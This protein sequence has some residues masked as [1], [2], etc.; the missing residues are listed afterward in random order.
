MEEFKVRSGS[1]PVFSTVYTQ[2]LPEEFTPTA[3]TW[4]PPSRSSDSG[5]GIVGVLSPRVILTF[6]AK[7]KDHRSEL[8]VSWQATSAM[9]STTW[10]SAQGIR[11]IQMSTWGLWANLEPGIETS[12]LECRRQATRACLS[13]Q[14]HR[15]LRSGASAHPDYNLEKQP[16]FLQ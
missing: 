14:P 1:K 2:E 12:W 4:L 9:V 10:P 6:F 16:S 13:S 5:L 3:T 7:T 15:R 8:L 11:L